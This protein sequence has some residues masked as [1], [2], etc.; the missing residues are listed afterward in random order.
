MIAV[1]F[2]LSTESSTFIKQLRAQQIGADAVRVVHTG[3]GEAACTR[4][5]REFLATN[6]PR[7]LIS[8]GFAGALTDELGVGDILL[9]KNYTSAR[10]LEQARSAVGETTHVAVL[11]TAAAITDAAADRAELAD[12]MG[13][14]AVD[15]ETA[16]IAQACREA[17]LPMI[18]LRAISDTPA[19]PMPAPPQVLFDLDAQRTD[20]ARLALHVAKH[21]SSALRLIAFARRI[22]M[23][24]ERLATALVTLTRAL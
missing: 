13:A 12:R 16:A 22:A 11:A 20:Y 10:L 21:P 6:A 24:R 8:S 4:A 14:I 18:S 15:M 3:V 19:A 7:L 1:T 5:M 9:A 23:V 2:A 17:S